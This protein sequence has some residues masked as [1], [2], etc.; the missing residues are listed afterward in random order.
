MSDTVA[1]KHDPQDKALAL[2]PIPTLH[3][4]FSNYNQWT[5]A[6]FL[7]VIYHRLLPFVIPR[8]SVPLICPEFTK[9]EDKDNWVR[10]QLHAYAIV[11][12]SIGEDV[13]CNM[14][15]DLGLSYNPFADR[16]YRAYELMQKLEVYKKILDER[17]KLLKIPLG[18]L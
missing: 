14:A 9:V 12:S 3:R 10:R 16:D 1:G 8:G 2:V 15:M 7:H 18:I 5:H 13:L 6:L 11:Y 4:D 17:S